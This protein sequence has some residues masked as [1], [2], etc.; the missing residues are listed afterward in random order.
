MKLIVHFTTLRKN[1]HILFSFTTLCFAL[2]AAAQ[3][4]LNFSQL[5]TGFAQPL[6]IKNAGDGSKRLFIAEQGGLI[7]IYKNGS[8]L[9]TPFLD[10]RKLVGVG[11]FKGIWSIAFS[12]N[13]IND[14]VFFVLYTD[15]N[16][17][18]AL[19]RYTVSKTNPDLANP[20]SAIVILNYPKSGAGHYGNIAFGSDQY[21]Y[22]SLGAG[23]NNGN[24]QNGK[25]DFG[26]MIRINVKVNKPPYYSI[27]ADNP[28][29][30]NNT[31]LGEIWAIGLRNAW[32]WSFDT[33]NQDMWLADVGQDS[34]EEVDYST[35]TQGLTGNNFGF[36]C[37]EGT[38]I[39]KLNGCGSKNNYVFPIF[40][41]HHDIPTGGECLIGGYVYRGKKYPSLQGYY[42]CA[43]FISANLWEI[44][45]NGNG[46]WN[47]Y[48]QKAGAPKGI[49]SFGQ[50]EA[51]EL[52]AV[53]GTFGALY[54]IQATARPVQENNTSGIAANTD[55]KSLI[56]PT[57]VSSGII[58]LDLKEKYQVVRITDITGNKVLEQDISN[59]PG[60]IMLHLPKLTAGNYFIECTGSDKILQRKIYVE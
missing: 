27:P 60:K 15:R 52:Y 7:K 47:S 41:Y 49:T 11:Q 29:I 19:A 13:F 48:L 12:P 51:G 37:Y 31:I 39:Y 40:E 25:T 50:D 38:E 59:S 21:L 24:S 5:A 17:N 36:Q 55:L 9:N 16:S 30:G 1:L 43:D 44:K 35:R 45:S 28:F 26:K 20:N 14:Q 23:N 4:A 54:T 33:N 58:T 57:F 2:S 42:V 56:Y 10:I 8:V 46:G 32:R 6:E 18:T 3:P 34:M 22:I 53:S